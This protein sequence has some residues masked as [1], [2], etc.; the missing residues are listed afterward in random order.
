MNVAPLILRELRA[1]SRRP[2]N[3]WLR[4]LAAGAVIL[5]FAAFMW[6]AEVAPSELGAQ[7][8][9]VLHYTL[10]VSFWIFAPL[11][12]ADCISSEQREGT[13]PLLFLTPL[14]IR[15]LIAAKNALHALRVLTLGLAA[16]P[17]LVMPF[18]IGGVALS[19]V[20]HALAQQATALVLGIAVGILASTK[21]G[22]T[23][24]VM[25]RAE[26]YALC[27][28]IVCT[29]CAALIGWGPF[30]TPIFLLG[31]AVFGW[32]WFRS[33]F[34]ASAKQ[35]AETWQDDP[36]ATS[37]PEW[38]Q[39]FSRS[40]FWQDV[41]RW[42]KSRTLDHN[43]VA[44]LQEY[45]WT[46]RL[47]KWGGCFF[48]LVCELITI[49]SGAERDSTL[50]PALIGLLTLG[51]AFGAAGSFRRERQS[52]L[53]ELMLVTPLSVRQVIAGRLW[54]IFSHFFPALAVLIVFCIGD[55]LL[56]PKAYQQ[57]PWALL[58][59]NPLAMG[60]SISLASLALMILG[61]YLSLW[62]VNRLL[63][64]VLTWLLAF[65]LP[66][67]ATVILGQLGPGHRSL[68]VPAIFQLLLAGVSLLLLYRNLRFRN[69]VKEE[70]AWA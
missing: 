26:L 10:L 11:M 59:P 63:A 40:V 3:Y 39:D 15:D 31:S 38:V 23:M 62:R 12:T 60:I 27:V 46:A 45:S 28:A 49:P 9:T 30:R 13:L 4:V 21:G 35:L 29:L 65:V 2:L 36:A 5:V 20:L 47:T 53:L 55:R 6:A 19:L 61:L 14:T 22:S 54:G 7:M 25:V 42:D 69:F 50:Q 58:F 67:F 8:F 70:R 56:F 48:L 68:T 51:I 33:L 17:V 66:A 41:F 32:L 64:C 34:R 16:L 18:V 52:G 43:P 1:E 24:Q 44:W 57:G 37:Q